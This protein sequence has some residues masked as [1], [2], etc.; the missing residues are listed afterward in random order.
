VHNLGINVS[1]TISP[2]ISPTISVTTQSVQKEP[3]LILDAPPDF[4]LRNVSNDAAVNV[5]VPDIR[6]PVPESARQKHRI[7]QA[8]I[9]RDAEEGQPEWVVQ[10]FHAGVH[11]H[12]AVVPAK[13]SRTLAYCV[14]GVGPLHGQNLVEALAACGEGSDFSCEMFVEFSDL[15]M[16]IRRWQSCHRLRYDH[17]RKEVSVHYIETLSLDG[18]NY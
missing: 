12:V 2:I 17:R 8:L 18:G 3:K 11:A 16:P 10:F 1:P 13:E 15:G 5:T 9:R 4:V 6:L 7:G 14:N